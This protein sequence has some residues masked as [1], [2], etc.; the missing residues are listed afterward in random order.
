MSGL[1]VGE[2]LSR[3]LDP[4]I[5]NFLKVN[6]TDLRPFFFD[7]S[8]VF[9]KFVFKVVTLLVFLKLDNKDLIAKLVLFRL[10]FLRMKRLK[11]RDLVDL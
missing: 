9:I 7:L 11:Y 2:V 1:N 6:E 5:E 8:W 4:K 3:L 10:V